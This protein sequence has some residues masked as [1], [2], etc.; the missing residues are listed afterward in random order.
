[1][2]HVTAD[3]PE[4]PRVRSR[5]GPTPPPTHPARAPAHPGGR[6]RT[7]RGRRTT[8][9]RRGCAR[10]PGGRSRRG[11]AGQ[12]AVA[13]ARRATRAEG[14]GDSGLSRLI[15]LHAFNAAGDA[16][17][18][19]SLAGTL[20]F[21]VPTGEARGQVALFLGPDDA[22]LRDRRAADRPVPRPLQPRPPLGHRRDHG[23]PLLPLLGAGDGRGHRV[24]RGCS[25]RRWAAS[26][27]PRRTASRAPP[28]SPGCCRPTLHAGQGQRPGLAGRRG[29]AP[30]CRRRSPSSPRPSGPSGRCATRFL[31]FVLAT[32]WAIRL[33]REGR[34]QPRRGRAGADRLDRPSARPPAA[35]PR[36]R[37]PGRGGLRAAGQLRTALALGLPHHVHGV[38]AARQPDRRLAARGAARRSSSAQRASATPSASRSG[39]CSTPQPGA[40]GGARPAGR[41]RRRDLVAALF[42]GLLAARAARPD[43]GPG[44]VAG[45]A[46]ARLDDPARRP[47]AASRPARS[48]APTPRCSW[49]G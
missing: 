15:E 32:I 25:R 21:Q 31:V 33:P 35:R 34:L 12:F 29:R 43:R 9:V 7:P 27:P 40:D 18:A 13:Q 2:V 45:Q 47:R 49:R 42:Y 38:P 36:T 4:P 23:D 17:V 48:P 39:R 28:P 8:R 5:S 19:I 20:F 22:A 1:M 37:I 3:R 41:R 16:A 46:V 30:V 6:R 26:S 24:R 14:A 44:A 11:T 10:S